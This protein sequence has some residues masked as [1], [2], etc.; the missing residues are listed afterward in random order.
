[1]VGSESN[2][3]EEEISRF[4][5]EMMD[6]AIKKIPRVKTR[7]RPT[8]IRFSIQ[9]GENGSSITYVARLNNGKRAKIGAF[10]TVDEYKKEQALHVDT[11]RKKAG[12]TVLVELKEP[13]KKVNVLVS[14]TTMVLEIGSRT[15]RITLPGEVDAVRS[16]ALINNNV[17]EVNLPYGKTERVTKIKMVDRN[18]KKSR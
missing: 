15:E 7:L 17:L 12:V 9:F 16:K 10:K 6:S 18:A 4:A 2:S 5:E 14:G 13:E 1:M 11:I 3:E 8:K